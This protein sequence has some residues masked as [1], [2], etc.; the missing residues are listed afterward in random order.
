M[1]AQINNKYPINVKEPQFNPSDS[2]DFLRHKAKKE[3]ELEETRKSADTILEYAITGNSNEG[4][5][6]NI[7]PRLFF[8]VMKLMSRNFHVKPNIEHLVSFVNL[9]KDNSTEKSSKN[10]KQR[11]S[12]EIKL[13]ESQNEIF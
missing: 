7:T 3:I 4:L 12:Y 1:K 11:D 10:D 13:R 8:E 9:V 6:E 5:P 2:N